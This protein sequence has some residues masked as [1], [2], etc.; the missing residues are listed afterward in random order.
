MGKRGKIETSETPIVCARGLWR[1]RIARHTRSSGRPEGNGDADFRLSVTVLLSFADPWLAWGSFGQS[2]RTYAAVAHNLRLTTVWS[3]GSAAPRCFA[4]CGLPLPSRSPIMILQ[5]RG[6]PS[7]AYR[8]FACSLR[9]QDTSGR[10]HLLDFF[11]SRHRYAMH[12]R[13]TSAVGF[14]KY[15]LFILAS[16]DLICRI[17]SN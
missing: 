6:W 14:C 5:C 16:R 9:L 7:F 1:A 3:W 2:M 17:P 10:Y 13:C 11:C 15:N 4:G 8:S 12:S